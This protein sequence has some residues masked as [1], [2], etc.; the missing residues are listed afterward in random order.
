MMA[1]DE[2]N[3]APPSAPVA[4]LPR[5]PSNAEIIRPRNAD[6]SLLILRAVLSRGAHRPGGNTYREVTTL[7]GRTHLLLP[8]LSLAGSRNGP[9]RKSREI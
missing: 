3:P 9:Q 5:L 4:R 7:R 1:F 2:G 8:A 6:V